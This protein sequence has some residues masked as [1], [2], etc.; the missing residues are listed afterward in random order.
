MLLE[1]RHQID[2][3][4]AG[5]EEL[6]L[7]AVIEGLRGIQAELKHHFGDEEGEGCLE[8]AVSR[9]PNLSGKEQELIAQHPGLLAAVAELIELA[10]R[11]EE[12]E[13]DPAEFGRKYEELYDRLH[14][15]ELAESR[16]MQQAFSTSLD[17]ENGSGVH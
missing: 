13:T 1:A 7:R 17:I 3:W 6:T 14:A 4:R 8:E 11:G 2:N 12:R 10:E 5:G 9:Y 16:L 15:H